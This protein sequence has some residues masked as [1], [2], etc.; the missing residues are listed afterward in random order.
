VSTRG[1]NIATKKGV[2]VVVAQGNSGSG[3]KVSALYIKSILYSR[4]I[5]SSKKKLVNAKE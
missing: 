2:V 4:V 5:T 1:V 3:S